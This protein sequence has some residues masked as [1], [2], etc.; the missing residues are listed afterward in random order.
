MAEK[1]IS[2]MYEHTNQFWGQE[3]A[4]IQIRNMK[5]Y[6]G[7]PITT[8]KL[9]PQVTS[10]HSIPFPLTLTEKFSSPSV[11]RHSLYF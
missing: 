5:C 8:E 9:K 3:V 6:F 2:T 1:P 7:V 4:T 11:K 10:L